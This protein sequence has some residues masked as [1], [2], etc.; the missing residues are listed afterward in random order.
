MAAFSATLFG[1]IVIV[2][3][4]LHS[5]SITVFSLQVRVRLLAEFLREPLQGTS[6]GC[7]MRGSL[8]KGEHEFT[9]VQNTILQRLC[10]SALVHSRLLHI[11]TQATRPKPPPD[12]DQLDSS[13]QNSNCCRCWCDPKSSTSM[14]VVPISS[15]LSRKT[16]PYTPEHENTQGQ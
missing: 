14:H 13:V 12:S 2:W 3:L 8:P 7:Y 16:L 5:V 10:R 6:S 11:K 15:S 4:T 9:K 1:I